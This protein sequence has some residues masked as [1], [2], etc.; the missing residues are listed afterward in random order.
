MDFIGFLLVGYRER[1]DGIYKK[2][3]QSTFF[4]KDDSVVKTN[5][6]LWSKES[7]IIP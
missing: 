1:N 7:N 3:F 6:E 5:D 4:L 2:Y